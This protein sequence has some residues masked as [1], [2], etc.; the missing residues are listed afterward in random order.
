MLGVVIAVAACGGGGDDEAV[1]AAAVSDGAAADDASAA[2]APPPGTPDAR[3][4]DA[5]AG[6]PDAAVAD[7]MMSVPDASAPDAMLIPD[8][9]PPDAMSIPDAMPLPDAMPIPDAPP[10]ADARVFSC[11]DGLCQAAENCETCPG[12]CGACP[13]P[14][15][16]GGSALCPHTECTAGGPLNASCSACAASICAVDS[17]CCTTSWDTICVGEVTSVCGKSCT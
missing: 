10:P 3:P 6:T 15:V 12:D 5:G 11:G 17:F 4:P 13:T 9:S 8:A 1:D 16:D 14:D 2:D 7:A